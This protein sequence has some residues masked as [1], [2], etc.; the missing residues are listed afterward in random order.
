VLCVN[1][2]ATGLGHTLSSQDHPI[3][4][5]DGVCGFCNWAV[6][7]ILK[8]DRRQLFRF[9]SLQSEF[10][11]RILAKHGADASRLD[12]LYVV[13]HS[14]GQPDA[15]AGQELLLSRSDAVLFVLNELGGMWRALGRILRVLP[16]VV[17]DCG[18]RTFAK[19][20]YSI[21]GRYDSCPLP[22]PATRSRFLDI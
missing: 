8:Y 18:Y 14:S 2:K 21:F 17:A 16:R 3:L 11:K 4:L 10:A 15:L 6:R 9:A 7:F 22:S 1:R 13:L 20:R 19:H 5:Y 12:T